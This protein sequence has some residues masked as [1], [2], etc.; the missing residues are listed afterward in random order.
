MNNNYYDEEDNNSTSKGCVWTVSVCSPLW[1]G[2]TILIIEHSGSF[3]NVRRR[4]RVPVIPGYCSFIKVK[5][6]VTYLLYIKKT[7]KSFKEKLH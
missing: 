3:L 7:F 5:E 4:A 2:S 1:L 6:T